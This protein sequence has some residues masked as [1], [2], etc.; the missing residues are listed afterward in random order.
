MA[1]ATT[2]EKLG[3]QHTIQK[4]A[5][6][7]TIAT[8]NLYSI[9]SPSNKTT[10]IIG[11]SRRAINRTKRSVK[12]SPRVSLRHIV[13]KGMTHDSSHPRSSSWLSLYE[14]KMMKSRAKS[15]SKLHYYT[16]KVS[17]S[18]SST[19]IYSSCSSAKQMAAQHA[20]T[21]Y[22]IKGESLRGME[23]IT[24]ITMGIKRDYLR[25]QA[26]S[27]AVKEQ[28]NQCLSNSAR[29]R[30]MIAQEYGKLT[31]YALSYSR[32]VAEEDA[33]AAAAILEEDLS[34][35]SAPVS[36][37]AEINSMIFTSCTSPTSV[38]EVAS[39]SQQQ[40]QQASIFSQASS[41]SFNNF[42]NRLK[43]D[44]FPLTAWAGI[45]LN[46]VYNCNS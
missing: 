27:S 46:G 24:D 40:Q 22:E 43:T 35:I 9:M 19:S 44:S 10:S 39:V 8:H 42:L 18:E 20:P 28:A 21:S 37:G 13:C 14:I 16:Q 34:E 33:R 4:I 29:R 38:F 5:K 32:R 26:I 2:K 36:F 1:T 25:K 17:D 3:T 11:S 45:K 7:S 15:F 12:F 23:H 41:G 31:I 6:K 30:Q